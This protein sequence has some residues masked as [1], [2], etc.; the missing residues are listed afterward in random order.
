MSKT[1]EKTVSFNA[2]GQNRESMDGRERE[3]WGA[4]E[5][6]SSTTRNEDQITPLESVQNIEIVND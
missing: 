2:D 4:V 6:L 5:R 1:L 3:Y